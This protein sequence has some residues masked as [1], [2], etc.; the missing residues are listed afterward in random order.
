MLAGH[1]WLTEKEKKIFLFRYQ[2]INLNLGSHISTVNEKAFGNILKQ[3]QDCRLSG[4][5]RAGL[6]QGGRKGLCSWPSLPFTSP[7]NRWS[8]C[9]KAPQRD[10]VRPLPSQVQQEQVGIC[11]MS[12]IVLSLAAFPWRT[13]AFSAQT[14]SGHWGQCS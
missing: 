1:S 12:L 11:F 14:C 9:I 3:T 8:G 5:A 2:F 4:E 10:P 7:G 6:W 13:V